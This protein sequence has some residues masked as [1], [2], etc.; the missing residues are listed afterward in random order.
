M[1]VVGLFSLALV[2]VAELSELRGELAF[3]RFL[4]FRRFVPTC[5]NLGERRGAIEE[6]LDETELVMTYSR[7]NSDALQDVAATLLAWATAKEMD[8]ALRLRLADTAVEAAALAVRAAPTNF[9]AWL[10]LA[11]TQAAIGLAEQARLCL[12]RAQALAPPGRKLKLIAGPA[13]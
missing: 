3:A 12:E 10:W 5:V 6:A 7:A 9:E 1:A 11:Q 4:H 13:G 8:A 2:A